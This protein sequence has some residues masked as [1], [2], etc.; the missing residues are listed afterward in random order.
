MSPKV[1]FGALVVLAAIIA[2][3]VTRAAAAK[4]PNSILGKLGSLGS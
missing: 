1:K 2:I 3:N 4:D